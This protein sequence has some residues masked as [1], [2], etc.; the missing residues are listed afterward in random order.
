[1]NLKEK[2]RRRVGGYKRFPICT[3][4]LD[5]NFKSIFTKIQRELN[6]PKYD[7]D[8]IIDKADDAQI[9]RMMYGLDE[10]QLNE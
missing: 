8:E 1:M 10:F 7:I 5:I 6:L 3:L 9:R 4:M 2:L